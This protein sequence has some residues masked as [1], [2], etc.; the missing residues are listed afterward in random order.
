MIGGSWGGP[1]GGARKPRKTLEAPFRASGGREIIK[2]PLVFIAFPPYGVPW[3]GPRAE[4][5]NR[6]TGSQPFGEVVG[7]FENHQKQLVFITFLSVCCFSGGRLGALSDLSRNYGEA[8][9]GQGSPFSAPDGRFAVFGAP[10]IVKKQLCFMAKSLYWSARR[11]GWRSARDA[12][13]TAGYHRG[14]QGTL[15]GSLGVLGG[16]LGSLGAP[17]GTLG[18]SPRPPKGLREFQ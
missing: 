5:I 13:G 8:Q 6:K 10:K 18:G 12:D 15:G 17:G 9:G 2:T 14:D 16:S 11:I 1:G 7:P 3:G 4:T